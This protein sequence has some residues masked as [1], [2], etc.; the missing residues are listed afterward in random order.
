MTEK[1]RKIKYCFLKALS[2][3][4][5]CAF[6]IYAVSEHFPIWRMSHGTVR[7][8]GAGGIICL[9]VILIVF[10]KAVFDFIS[11]R[12]KL[13]NAPPMAI[14]IVLLIVSYILQFIN[15][16]IQDLTTVFWMGLLGCFIGTILTFIAENFYGKKKED[17]DGGA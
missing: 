11:K 16:F 8:I 12:L 15:S 17:G 1:K 3:I 9:I 14:W 13:E 6:P 7:S 2:V 10:R 4:V 5:A